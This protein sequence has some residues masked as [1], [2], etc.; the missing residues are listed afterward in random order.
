MD[1]AITTIAGVQNCC[2]CKACA[3]ACPKKAIHFV[4]DRY[5]FAYPQIDEKLCIHCGKCLKVCS[6]SKDKLAASTPIA[7]YAAVHK[8]Q[9][10]LKKSSSGG[11][12]GALAEIVLE[13]GGCVF[14]AAYDDD[15]NV[16]HIMVDNVENLDCLRG[17][18]YVQSD[19][20]FTYNEVKELLKNNRKVLFSGTP[21]QID[22]LKSVLGNDNTENLF[23]VDLICH[24]VPSITVFHRYIE[25]LEKK[26]GNRITHY[27]FRSKSGRWGQ[28]CADYDY[29]SKTDGNIK[30]RILGR[31]DEY[32]LTEFLGGNLS[33]ENCFSCKYATDKRVGDFTMG[34]FW[35]Y[36]K[37]NIELD[38]DN[39]L[40]VL[41]V[42]T[43]KAN[44]LMSRLREKL[45]LQEVDYSI[46]VAGNECLRK[47]STRGKRREHVLNLIVSG[48]SNQVYS[49]F[50][51][52][53]LSS[54]IKRKIKSFFK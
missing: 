14:G 50:K 40:S 49:E 2:G 53:L 38:R 4:P 12:F 5:G 22:A 3:N 39:G 19:I 11:V 20:G 15:M 36:Q 34:D 35:G 16:R 17:S 6:Y 43:E 9:A 51:M 47:P 21:C 26:Q 13:E 10:V 28:L 30:K 1:K 37:G 45:S 54:K 29:Q 48:K 25:Y 24:G 18:K 42:N 7:C 52:R 27:T 23:T 44:L 46:A 33:R 41:L 31:Y 8:N 32:Y